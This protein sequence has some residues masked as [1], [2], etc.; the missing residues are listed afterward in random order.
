MVKACFE[1]LFLMTNTD[2]VVDMLTLL[3]DGNFEN[4]SLSKDLI[5]YIAM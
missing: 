3:L 1:E 5:K 2:N 4:I